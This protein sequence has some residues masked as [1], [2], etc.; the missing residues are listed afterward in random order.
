M[1]LG[2]RLPAMQGQC[3]TPCNVRCGVVRSGNPEFI[4]KI[5]LARQTRAVPL[6][7]TAEPRDRVV[8]ISRRSSTMVAILWRG[9]DRGM[10][11]GRDSDTAAGHVVGFVRTTDTSSYNISIVFPFV[12]DC[13]FLF[14]FTIA[15]AGDFS[16][17]GVTS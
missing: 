6:Y 9:H 3:V 8:D 11:R 2:S 10:S 7:C 17:V 15:K 12:L 4:R 5:T 14:V 1:H 13:S 16:F